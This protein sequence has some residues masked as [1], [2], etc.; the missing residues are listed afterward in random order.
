MKM[1][2]LGVGAHPDDLEISCG[3]TL[4]KYARMRHRVVMVCMT[5]GR[6]GRLHAPARMMRIRE[7]EAR[8]AA[9]IIGAEL[10][11]LGHSD[12]GLRDDFRLRMELADLIRQVGPGVIIT[13]APNGLNPDHR[14][15][16]KIVCDALIPAFTRTLKLKHRACREM[17]V[18]YYMSTV[19]GTDFNPEE[20]VDISDLIRIKLK[21]LAR[22]ESQVEIYRRYEKRDFL[23]FV[24]AAAMVDGFRCGVKYAEGFRKL[25]SWMQNRPCR[26]LP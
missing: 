5:D 18:L 12:L 17:P 8:S 9:K 2:V 26:L 4:A 24:E 22:H 1:A 10:V 16:S 25:H 7:R 14:T 6:Y 13:H 23:E 11:W 3:G 19:G 20:Y 15:T 21:M